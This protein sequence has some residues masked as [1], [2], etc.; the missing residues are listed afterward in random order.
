[1]NSFLEKMSEA[2]K[3]L[4][5]FYEMKVKDLMQ[6]TKSELPYVDE[7]ADVTTVLSLLNTTDHVWVM[8]SSEPTRLLGIITES[9]ALVLLSPPLTSLQSFDKPDSR[10]LQ[11]GEVVLA[12]EVMSKKPVA[13]S[14]DET[15]RDVLL[16]MKEQRIKHLAVVDEHQQLIGEI[17]LNNL[18]Q[19]YSKQHIDFVKETD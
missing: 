17:S 13:V 14:P 19:E 10:S 1:M 16:K 18:I 8:D 12:E 9:D 11:F 5:E 6:T 3:S 4:H 7:K 2:K 15:V